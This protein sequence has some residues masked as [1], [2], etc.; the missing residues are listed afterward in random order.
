MQVTKGNEFNELNVELT[1][2]WKSGNYG[3]FSKIKN[4]AIE[5]NTIGLIGIILAK[6]YNDISDFIVVNH[7]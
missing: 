1:K 5:I 6:E 2:R 3:K 4:D 7:I